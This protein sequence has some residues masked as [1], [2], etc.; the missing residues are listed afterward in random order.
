MK[1]ERYRVMIKVIGKQMGS[2]I[3]NIRCKKETLIEKI[4]RRV[5]T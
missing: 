1:V 5:K 3:I 4:T 2:N